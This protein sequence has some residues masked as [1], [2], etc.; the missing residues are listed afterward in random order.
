MLSD[1]WDERSCW[2]LNVHPVQ[3]QNCCLLGGGGLEKFRGPCIKKL[4]LCPLKLH[5]SQE[6]AALIKI[7]PTR[8]VILYNW[9]KDQKEST[10]TR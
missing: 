3:K 10:L 2:S 1:S 6:K 5:V 4:S 8:H 9:T 7:D